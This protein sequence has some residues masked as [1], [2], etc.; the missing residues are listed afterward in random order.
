MININHFI[1]LNYHFIF[2]NENEFKKDDY[3]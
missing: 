1:I 2:L 3:K